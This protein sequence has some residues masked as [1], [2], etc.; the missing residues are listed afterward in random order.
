M[1][2][3]IACL[4]ALLVTMALA[5]ASDGCR[6]Q[7]DDLGRVLQRVQELGPA[8]E[9]STGHKLITTRG[10]SIGDL[11]ATPARLARGEEADV[12]IMDGVGVDLLESRDS[13]RPGSRIPLAQFFIGMVVRAGQPSQHQHDG[14][15]TQDAA[16]RQIHRL[17]GRVPA[18][19]IR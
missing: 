6:C 5:P 16:R 14:W 2:R 11:P 9:K 12:V 17:F 1:S 10:P 3:Y 7:G 4:F 13:A 19:I 8:F 15:L 18:A